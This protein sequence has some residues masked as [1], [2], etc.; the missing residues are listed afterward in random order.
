[1]KTF[2]LICL[3]VVC[4]GFEIFLCYSVASW[5]AAPVFGVRFWVVFAGALL[6]LGPSLPTVFMLFA[7][8]FIN[9]R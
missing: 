1:M 2:L 5:I 7:L 9:K 6:I 4:I 3:G 8:P